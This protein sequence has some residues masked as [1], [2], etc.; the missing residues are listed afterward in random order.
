[1]YN[2]RKLILHINLILRSEGVT[3][4]ETSSYEGS[5][6]WIKITINIIMIIIIIIIIIVIII[7]LKTET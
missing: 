4:T 3:A 5:D 2:Y 6:T 7:M 1:M